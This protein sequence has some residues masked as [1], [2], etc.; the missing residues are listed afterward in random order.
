MLL[1][2]LHN[3]IEDVW[4]ELR[5]RAEYPGAE[6]NLKAT[7]TAVNR[8]FL[9][10]VAKGQITKEEAGDLKFVGPVA[11]TWQGRKGYGGETCEQCLAGLSKEDRKLVEKWVSKIA[12]CKSTKETIKLA[13]QVYAELKAKEEA[14]PKMEGEGKGVPMKGEG[15]PAEGEGEGDGEGA[16]GKATKKAG[17]GK[18]DA[19][20]KGMDAD[21]VGEAD[22][23]DAREEGEPGGGPTHAEGHEPGREEGEES[24]EKDAVAEVE[25]PYEDFDLKSVVEKELEKAKLTGAEATKGGRYLPFSTK[26]DKWHHRRLDTDKSRMLKVYPATAYDLALERMQG[27]VNAIRRKLERALVSKQQRDWVGGREVGRLD[28]RRF[29]AVMAGKTSVF[30]ERTDRAEIDTALT[31]LVDLSGSMGHHGKDRTARDC[32]MALAEAVD[33]TG[34]A[35]EIV[36]FDNRRE[37]PKGWRDQIASGIGKGM[38]YARWEPLDMV[39]FKAFEDRLFE[40]KG[41]IYHIPSFVGGEN[42]DGEAVLMA[43]SR[44]KARSERRKVLLTLSDGAPQCASKSHDALQKHLR[45]AVEAVRKDGCAIL[46]IGI[47]DRT[48][49]KYYPEYVVVNDLSELAGSALGLL[50]KQLLGERVQM[51]RSALMS[52]AS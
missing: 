11:I 22:P 3:A 50:S 26:E 52:A 17:G 9:E 28:S 5:V 20:G 19:K 39:I 7:T 30:K 49:A 36:G 15:E 43:Y 23:R 32:V 45:T 37:L 8:E 31:I 10:R 21:E 42:S 34:V 24:G 38:M 33:R 48:V 1:K 51:D 35:Y 47:Q 16:E 40:A 2:S 14:P 4:L 6:Q 29:A 46:G 18:S 27:E 12:S 44:L 41:A 25:R 13:E